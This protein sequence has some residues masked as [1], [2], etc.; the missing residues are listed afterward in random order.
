MIISIY[1]KAI[2]TE[3]CVFW[4]NHKLSY[5]REIYIKATTENVIDIS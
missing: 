1:G 3:L 4:D 5:K 2:I